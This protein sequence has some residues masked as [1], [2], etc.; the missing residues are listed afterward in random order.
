M[1]SQREQAVADSEGAVAAA[2]AA[3]EGRERA[4]AAA[5][6]SL[7][8]RQAQLD[9]GERVAPLYAAGGSAREARA[10]AEQKEGGAL[11]SKQEH[12]AKGALAAEA[13]AEC[14]RATESQRA[15]VALRT[16]HTRQLPG[17]LGLAALDPCA[18]V[19]PVATAAHLPYGWRVDLTMYPAV[20]GR[21][22]GPL[23]R[24]E[25]RRAPTAL[26]RD[27]RRPTRRQAG[28]T[29]AGGGAQAVRSQRRASRV[30]PGIRGAKLLSTRDAVTTRTARG[31]TAGGGT[32]G[33]RSPSRVTA[34]LGIEG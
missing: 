9:E 3:L 2:A 7:Q 6:Q 4:V 18:S 13:K 16:R 30:P 26:R 21:R 14:L 19:G 11:E 28:G 12:D 15:K 33:P 1:V 22:Q 34:T 27:A 29:Q 17:P 32:D 24:D 20:A 25:D 23:R 31:K 10:P 8:H 5:E